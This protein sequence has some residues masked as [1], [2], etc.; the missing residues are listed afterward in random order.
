MA[1][2]VAVLIPGSTPQRRGSQ[3]HPHTLG[4]HTF[5]H[6]QW[7]A[8]SL[9]GSGVNTWGNQARG[10]GCR[11]KHNAQYHTVGALSGD[12]VG[13]G[14]VLAR[15]PQL[16]QTCTTGRREPIRCPLL[17]RPLLCPNPPRWPQPSQNGPTLPAGKFPLMKPF[18]CA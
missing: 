12:G 14:G 1:N 9:R 4:H 13:T 2:A 3:A 15:T 7:G 11:R 18:R 8:R 6:G 16:W 5:R 10:G 17:A